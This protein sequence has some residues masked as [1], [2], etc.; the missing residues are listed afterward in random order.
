[1]NTINKEL[2]RFISDSPTPFHTIENTADILQSCGF[3]ELAE[4]GKWGVEPGGKY[5]TVRGG[6]SVIAFVMPEKI[7]EGFSMISAH[8]DSP[9]FKIK[10][11]PERRSQ[12][13]V[14]LETEKYGGMILSTWL[15]R[16]LSIAGRMT[17]R[18][19]NG[20][21]GRTV[22]LKDTSLV[23]P[24]VAIHLDKTLNNGKVYDPATDMFPL[25]CEGGKELSVL[26][27]LSEQTGIRKEDIISHDLYLY[28]PEEPFVWDSYISSPRLDDLQCAFTCLRAVTSC[29]KSS[30]VQ[31]MCIF[32]NEEVG[33]GTY[34]GADSTFLYD[35]LSRI[36]FALGTDTDR[37]HE[38]LGNSYM[39][40]C[41]NAHACHPNHPE[42]SSPKNRV[43]MNRGIVIK[44]NAQ[45][46]YATDALSSSILKVICGRADIPYQIYSNRSDMPGGSTLGNIS[47]SHVSVPTVDVG[48]AQ[49]AMHSCLETAGVKDTAYMTDMLTRFLESDIRRSGNEYR[50]D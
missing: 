25:F 2:I 46:K 48:I 34:Q 5:F 8:S 9:C 27:A 29:A 24:N 7:P 37:F 1:M 42:M 30:S 26:D 17:Y 41:D 13:Y 22:V 16:K 33:S 3:T 38:M 11:D 20:F 6:S 44:H 40:S 19:E 45:Q 14:T 28:N 47:T 4:N 35:I 12:Y 50:I 10:E 18:T 21:A 49:L 23:I 39:I 43:Y 15:D 36:S 31:V 32:N